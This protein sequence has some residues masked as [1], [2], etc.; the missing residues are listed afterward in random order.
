MKCRQFSFY[1]DVSGLP[2]L[3]TAV[4]DHIMPRFDRGSGRT[5]GND[6]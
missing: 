6:S 4:E 3:M 1:L 5:L 2:L